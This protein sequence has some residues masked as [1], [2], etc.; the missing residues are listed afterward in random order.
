MSN[1]GRLFRRPL[2]VLRQLTAATDMAGDPW[3][4]SAT[5]GPPLL[6]AD[7]IRGLSRERQAPQLSF[8]EAHR[9]RG[10]R[11]RECEPNES[12][13]SIQPDVKVAA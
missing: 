12:H 8:D 2:S 13:Q 7:T 3:C 1:F 9:V 10:R 5:N 6:N 4:I 11:G